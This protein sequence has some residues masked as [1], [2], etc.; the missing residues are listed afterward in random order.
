MSI[1]ISS[2]RLLDF[3]L[4]RITFRQVMLELNISS[5]EDLFLL[6]CGAGLAMPIL[7]DGETNK[8]S[9]MMEEVL[10]RVGK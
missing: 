3:S 6:M 9:N 2:N 5:D 4:G 10:V 1:T 7:S 8:M